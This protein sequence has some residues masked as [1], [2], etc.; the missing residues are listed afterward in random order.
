MK[1]LNEQNRKGSMLPP[2]RFADGGDDGIGGASLP[3]AAGEQEHQDLFDFMLGNNY[4]PR[5]AACRTAQKF[6]HSAAGSSIT[7]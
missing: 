1:R 3:L 6:G 7:F 5:L 2:P 4:D